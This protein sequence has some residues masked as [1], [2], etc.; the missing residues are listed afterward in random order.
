MDGEPSYPTIKFLIRYGNVITWTVAA[1][2]ALVAVLAAAGGA[3]WWLV[4]AGLLVGGFLLVMMRSY[5]ELM[6]VVA[7]TLI[8]R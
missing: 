6:R 3:P 4:P 8:P 7:E 5:I 2:P 1:L